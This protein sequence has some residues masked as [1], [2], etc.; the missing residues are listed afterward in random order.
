MRR[1]TYLR[2]VAAGVA[3]VAIGTTSARAAQTE[4]ITGWSREAELLASDGTERENFGSAVAVDGDTALV[5]TPDDDPNGP[6]SG[7]VYVFER[8]EDGWVQRAKLATDDGQRDDQFGIAVAVEGDTALVGAPEATTANGTSTGAAYV[9]ERTDGT[10]SQTTKIASD[11]EG[12]QEFGSAVALNGDTAI[13]SA[14]ADDNDNGLGAGAAYV[15]ER[16]GGGWSQEAKLTAS[17][18]GELESLGFAVGLGTDVAVLGTAQ[19]EL[20]ATVFE[21]TDGDW[22]QETTL[23][24]ADVDEVDNSFGFSVSVDDGTALVGAWTDDGGTGAAYVFDG[25][26]G[27][28]SQEAKLSVEDGDLSDR[29]GIS[30]AL[31]G[32]RAL[33]GARNDQHADG[34]RAGSAYVFEGSDGEWTQRARVLADDG[35]ENDRFGGAVALAGDTALVGAPRVDTSGGENVGAAYVFRATEPSGLARYAGEDGVVGT[36][37]LRLAIDDWRAGDIDT[38]LLRDVIEAWRSGEPVVTPTGS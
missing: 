3:G 33:V 11:E 8:V 36:D 2:T 34:N 38:D 29:F 28:W 19:T 10:W 32:T 23:V 37:G 18:G 26:A 35:R 13:V 21:R 22:S 9:F 7:S 17:D 4:V 5:G 1:R 12:T 14:P 24:P 25:A 6:S 27:E 20:F 30:V 15:F 31:D 16:T